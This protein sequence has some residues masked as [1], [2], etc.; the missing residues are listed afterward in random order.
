MA[1][2]VMSKTFSIRKEILSILLKTIGAQRLEDVIGR[3]FPDS[4]PDS[5]NR[6]SA[7]RYAPRIRGSV[8]LKNGR[9]YT[10]SEFRERARRVEALQL[11]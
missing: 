7:S 1:R 11:P 9:Y 5:F 4:D 10:P 8:R 3:E 2:I 6:E